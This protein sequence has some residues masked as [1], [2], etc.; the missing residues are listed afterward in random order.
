[1]S[2][3]DQKVTVV[4]SVGELSVV[5]EDVPEAK[6]IIRIDEE[7]EE[8]QKMKYDDLKELVSEE[9]TAN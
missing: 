3:R 8:L 4:K 7:M 6:G 1:M 5:D 9:I 2:E